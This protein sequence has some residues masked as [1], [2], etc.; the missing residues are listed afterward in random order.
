MVS[1]EFE[2]ESLSF[3]IQ[4]EESVSVSALISLIPGLTIDSAALPPGV[5][6]IV[7]LEITSFDLDIVAVDLSFTVELPYTL[8]FFDDQITIEDAAVTV[9]AVLSPIRVCD[10]DCC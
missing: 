4:G 3:A 9:T 2:D 5:S 8:V 7:E 6:D 1:Y 10:L